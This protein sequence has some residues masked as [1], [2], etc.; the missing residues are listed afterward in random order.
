MEDLI[1]HIEFIL[2]HAA[3]AFLPSSP[4][5][6][7][8][9]IPPVLLRSFTSVLSPESPS[10][11][12]SRLPFEAHSSPPFAGKSRPAS[13]AKSRSLAA[14]HSRPPFAGKARPPNAGKS[15]APFTA[16]A[17]QTPNAKPPHER[18][19]RSRLQM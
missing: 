13:A 7:N 19:K 12:K 10:A 9:H 4:H 16:H 1:E 8:L 14:A 6:E 3:P 11:A 15:R 2:F 5:T 18:R 17:S